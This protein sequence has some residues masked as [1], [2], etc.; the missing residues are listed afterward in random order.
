V[1]DSGWVLQADAAHTLARG[2]DAGRAVVTQFRR[3]FALSATAILL[4]AAAVVLILFQTDRLAGQRARFAAAAA[5]ELKTPLSGLLLHSEMLA[6]GL[7]DP[8]HRTLYAKT[9]AKEA[10]RLGRVVTNMLDLSR[11]ERGARLADP[12]PGDLGAAVEDRIDRQ[13]PRLEDAGTTLEVAIAPELPPALFDVDALGQILDNLL[14]NAEKHTRSVENRLIRVEVD[15]N[16]DVLRVV[17]ADNGPGIPRQARRAL[18]SPFDRSPAADGTPG[19][20]LG[21]ALARS[22]AQAQD[23]GLELGSDE[24][25]G[26][27]FVLT[28]P[29]A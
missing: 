20:G 25:P 23:G 8:N 15:A 18:F 29:R 28:L 22:L 24:Q 4:A 5:H 9:V 21:L 1:A 3:T 19:L 16:D 26:A 10:E 13:R 12:R 2:A 17:V 11:L 7:G 6:E 14:D 27:T